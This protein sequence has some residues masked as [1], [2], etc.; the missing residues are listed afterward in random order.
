MQ[1]KAKKKKYLPSF[2]L[3]NEVY[4]PVLN[5]LWFGEDVDSEGRA[6]LSWIWRSKMWVSHL[7]N[8]LI[9]V[10]LGL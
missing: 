2:H 6:I 8:T 4:V 7:Q 3:L 5:F 9:P 1:R 10:S